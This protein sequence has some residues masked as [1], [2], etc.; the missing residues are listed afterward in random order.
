MMRRAWFI[1]SL[2]S[3]QGLLSAQ[4]PFTL[5]DV[6]ISKESAERARRFRSVTFEPRRVYNNVRKL[7]K[8]LVW[9]RNLKAATTAAATSGKPIFLIQALGDL[10]GYV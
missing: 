7:K 1:A 5:A 10:H 3:V 9:H 4:S 2:L 6:P 8:E